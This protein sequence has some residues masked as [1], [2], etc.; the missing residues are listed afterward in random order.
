MWTSWNT[1]CERR[2]ADHKASKESL[3]ESAPHKWRSYM[4]GVWKRRRKAI[5]T[6]LDLYESKLAMAQNDVAGVGDNPS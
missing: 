1:V 5:L 3:K 4:V 2:G 6:I